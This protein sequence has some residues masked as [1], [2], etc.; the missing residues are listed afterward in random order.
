MGETS[1]GE[2]VERLIRSVAGGD[3][4]AFARLYD[5]T[6]PTVFGIALRITRDRTRAEEVAQEVFTEL[7]NRAE[8]FDPDR[9]SGIAWISLMTRSRAIDRIRAEGSYRDAVDELGARP[10]DHPAGNP[11]PHPGEEAVLS[12]RRS[13]VREALSDLPEEQRAALEAS[14]FEGRTHREISARD[15]IPL[16]TVKSRIRAAVSKLE[17][18]LGPTL[19]SHR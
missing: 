13:L 8:S 1:G 14:F 6:S 19:D 12:E 18:A 10:V 3:E 5:R 17:S 2:T 7:W 15:G 4:R 16:G 9:G 11:G